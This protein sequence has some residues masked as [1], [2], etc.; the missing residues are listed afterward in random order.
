MGLSGMGLSGMGLSRIRPFWPGTL[1][2]HK[3]QLQAVMMFAG[4]VESWWF[5]DI[6]KFYNLVPD[7]QLSSAGQ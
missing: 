7:S 1:I 5:I 6:V 2:S 4:L 3:M